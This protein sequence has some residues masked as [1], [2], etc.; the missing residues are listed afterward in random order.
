MVVKILLA[1]FLA[2]QI[3]NFCRVPNVYDELLYNKTN[4]ELYTILA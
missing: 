4:K 2:D 3:E 1:G